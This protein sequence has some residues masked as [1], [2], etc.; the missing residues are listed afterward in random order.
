[1]ASPQELFESPFWSETNHPGALQMSR[2]ASAD[3][4]LGLCVVSRWFD[5][6]SFGW[7]L[8]GS[9]SGSPAVEDAYRAVLSVVSPGQQYLN[10][11]SL[12]SVFNTLEKRVQ[13]GEV[14]CEKCDLLDAFQQLISDHSSHGED[15]TQTGGT[16]EALSVSQ[17]PALAAGCVL[18]LSSPGRVCSA[19]R[20]GTWGQ[21]ARRFL[22]RHTHQDHHEELKVLLQELHAHYEPS[23]R[24]SCVTADDIT[25]EVNPS[26]PDQRQEVGAVLGR[27]LY[28]ALQGH[29]F[30]S[31]PLP[32]ESFFLDYIMERLGP[33]NFTVE[34][35]QMSLRNTEEH[36]HIH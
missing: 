35:K 21:E 14:S 20:Q 6:C 4:V 26:S 19:V 30:I 5:A 34:G 2:L 16:S 18:Y 1:M 12:G 27:V 7:G 33:E 28:H 32:E 10:R 8:L 17:F 15:E 9:V 25:T 3:L 22:R 23:D 24:E 29:C 36:G 31:R 13:C 11:E